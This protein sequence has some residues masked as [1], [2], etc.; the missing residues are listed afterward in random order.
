VLTT[1][2]EFCGFYRWRK[3]CN[4]HGLAKIKIIG[5]A[6]LGCI[7][8]IDQWATPSVLNAKRCQAGYLQ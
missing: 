5:R 4:C 1:T 3:L 7:P 2:Y 6:V 8:D